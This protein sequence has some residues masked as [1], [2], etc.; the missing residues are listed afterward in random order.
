MMDGIEEFSSERWFGLVELDFLRR[1]LK[2]GVLVFN[3]QSRCIARCSITSLP[4]IPIAARGEPIRGEQPLGLACHARCFQYTN[5]T[6]VSRA[7][8]QPLCQHTT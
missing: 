1:I 4:A 6:T 3:R 2:G 8:V 7:D 5:C